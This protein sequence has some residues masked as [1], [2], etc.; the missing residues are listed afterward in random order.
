[1]KNLINL[2]LAFC[3]VFIMSCDTDPCNDVP[4][5]DFGTCNEG[6]CECEL[7]YELD[8]DNLCNQLIR[9]KFLG[10][11]VVADVCD[12]TG[13]SS[14]SVVSASNAEVTKFNVTNF[15]GTFNNFVV[16]DIEGSNTFTIP[17]QEP[18]SDG[19]YVESMGDATISDDGNTITLTYKVT[20]E[21]NGI[22]ISQDECT[23][24][25]TK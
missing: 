7:G 20:E 9:E 12:N 17:R 15:W 24:T 18:D 19:Y 21:Q 3:A 13:T 11:W 2:C 10:T 14:F 6:S 1:M 25:W 8:G 22:V 4:C 5:G 23:S 16:A